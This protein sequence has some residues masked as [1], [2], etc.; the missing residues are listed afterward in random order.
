MAIDD[1]LSML[2]PV[3]N[4]LGLDSAKFTPEEE[5]EVR[6]LSK[7]LERYTMQQ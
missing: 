5:K 1:I 4:G 3:V 7:R 6:K 2:H